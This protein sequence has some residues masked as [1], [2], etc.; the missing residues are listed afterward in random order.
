MGDILHSSTNYSSFNEENGFEVDVFEEM[1]D[2]N[3]SDVNDINDYQN[4]RLKQAQL[5]PEEQSRLTEL[6]KRLKNK[7]LSVELINKT[8]QS[9][10][11]M[12]T[13]FKNNTVALVEKCKEDLN[14]FISNTKVEFNSYLDGCKATILNYMSR[15]TTKAEYSGQAKYY[16]CNIVT[17]NDGNTTDLYICINDNNGTGIT[18]ISPTTTAYWSKLSLKGEKGEP[19]GNLVYSGEWNSLTTYNN[20]ALVWFNGAFYF[21][22]VD[23]NMGNVPTQEKNDYWEYWQYVIPNKSI[24]QE[25]LA[26]EVINNINN[27]VDVKIENSKIIID[28]T[29][30]LKYIMGIDNGKPY[31]AK[32]ISQ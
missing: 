22:K 3:A 21:S 24:T 14:T 28:D 1:F 15:L 7:I 23:N 27:N 9:V 4:L 18:G 12:Q 2:F 31:M 11:Y 16:Q 17:Y 29:T 25:K 10:A 13:Y 20:T 5:T 30:E 6:M 32:V 19:G 26:D 8:F